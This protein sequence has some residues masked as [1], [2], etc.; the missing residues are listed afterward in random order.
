M[1][2]SQVARFR[3]NLYPTGESCIISVVL[4]GL[5]FPFRKEHFHVSSLF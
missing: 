5:Y 1:V 4:A 2:K 3:F